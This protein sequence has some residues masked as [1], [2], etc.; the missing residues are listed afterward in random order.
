MRYLHLPIACSTDR[1]TTDSARTHFFSQRSEFKTASAVSVSTAPSACRDLCAT[2]AVL[3]DTWQPV[4]TSHNCACSSRRFRMDS[5]LQGC[6]AMLLEEWFPTFRLNVGNHSPNNTINYAAVRTAVLV[7]IL[8]VYGGTNMATVK[9]LYI[10]I[11]TSH[12]QRC[13]CACVHMNLSPF[14]SLQ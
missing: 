5:C 7:Q 13:V 11:C 14:T 12:G 6:D 1:Q 10:V 9:Q 2:A 4:C 8:H 3:A